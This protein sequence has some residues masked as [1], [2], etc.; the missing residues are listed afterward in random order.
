[1]NTSLICLPNGRSSR[2]EFVEL[3]TGQV[4]IAPP[5]ARL[6]A[7]STSSRW[8]SAVAVHAEEVAKTLARSAGPTV[9]APKAATRGAGGQGRGALSRGTSQSSSRVKRLPSACRGC[10]VVLD[11]SD[12]IYCPDCVPAFEADRT[13]TLVSAA[14]ESLSAMRSSPHD[15][16]QSEQARRKRI[17]KAREMSLAARAWEREHGPVAVHGAEVAAVT[18]AP[19]VPLTEGGM[20]A[21]VWL[22]QVRGPC[23][24]APGCAVT[25]T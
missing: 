19:H 9:R 16:A 17:E 22:Q 20:V 11:A 4:R 13:A 18:T 10:G 5:L 21:E 23:G 14:K 12:R 8:E 1:M 15:P 6:L 7:E 24:G 25:R 2:R 3:P